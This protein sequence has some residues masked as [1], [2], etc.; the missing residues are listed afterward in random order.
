MI[1]NLETYGFVATT[2]KLKQD[3]TTKLN[4]KGTRKLSMAWKSSYWTGTLI[5][6]GC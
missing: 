5:K 1:R 2:T 6:T 4:R 3:T